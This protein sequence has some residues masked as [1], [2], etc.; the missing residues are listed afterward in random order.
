MPASEKGVSTYDLLSR[1]CF[2]NFLE[3]PF[4][5]IVAGK[6]EHLCRPI[7]IEKHEL[8][9]VPPKLLQL[10]STPFSHV[11]RAG[12]NENFAVLAGRGDHRVGPTYLPYM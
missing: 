2:E 6:S 12:Q 7:R 8:S 11:R 10:G 4:R 5:S 9:K 3:D 1:L